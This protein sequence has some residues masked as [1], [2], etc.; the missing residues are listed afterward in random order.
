MN[1]GTGKSIDKSGI[2]RH[3]AKIFEEGEL[4]ESLAVAKIATTNPHGKIAD[5]MQYLSTKQYNFDVIISISHKQAVEKA[6]QEYGIFN[7]TQPIEC[8]FDKRVKQYK[9]LDEYD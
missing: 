1:E 7:R 5:N 3:L 4:D 9:G 2:I 6:Y 8:D